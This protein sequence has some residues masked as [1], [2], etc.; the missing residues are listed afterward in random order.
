[1]FGKAIEADANYALA[2]A[3]LAYS[4]AWM[5][6]FV[7]P[8]SSWVERAKA[9]LSRADALDPQLAE[10]HLVRYELAWS[11]FEGFN[12]DRAIE[13]LRLA[14][15]LNPSVGHDH[16]G[17]LLAH[18][19]LEDP[20]IREMRRALE[21]DPQSDVVRSRVVEAYDLVVRPQEALRESDTLF[22]GG[23]I[24]PSYM[25][26]SLLWTGQFPKARQ[27]IEKELAARPN[28]PFVLSSQALYLA[29]TG[30][31]RAAEAAIPSFV[32]KGRQSR[33][34]HHLTYNVACIYALQGK[35]AEAVKWLRTTVDT[36]MPN[37]TLFSRDPHLD[38]IRKD[39]AFIQ[40]MA[41]LKPRFEKYQQ[42]FR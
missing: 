32:E 11:A 28:E 39:P 27:V 7:D 4:Y 38:K 8:S 34:F 41:E 30:D 33:A 35:S 19:G 6:L 21:I 1:M 26:K 42:E 36:G 2:H 18:I 23:G 3:Q 5:A 9:S 12:I 29:L 37:F 25:R 24:M 17:I 31:T 14:Q 15:K 10:S 22:L 20:A 16:L 40:F 13:E